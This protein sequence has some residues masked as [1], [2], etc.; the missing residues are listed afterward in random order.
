MVWGDLIFVF[1]VEKSS[2]ESVLFAVKHVP[3][4]RLQYLQSGI[5]PGVHI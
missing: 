1:S 2:L 5:R 4:F 3:R